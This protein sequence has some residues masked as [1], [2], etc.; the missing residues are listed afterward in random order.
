[1][2]S[3]RVTVCSESSSSER[4]YGVFQ[5]SVANLFQYTFVETC[6]AVLNFIGADVMATVCLTTQTKHVRTSDPSLKRP[7][8]LL[9]C[10]L[11]FKQ[12]VRGEKFAIALAIKLSTQAFDL[13]RSHSVLIAGL[14]RSSN[15]SSTRE[16][17]SESVSISNSSSFFMSQNF[18]NKLYYGSS[19]RG[20]AYRR[21]K[22]PTITG[23]MFS[24]CAL[25]SS[26]SYNELF[27]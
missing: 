27:T 5:C 3:N 13:K 19:I 14:I 25:A 20:F 2:G 7:E 6:I 24:I 26:T 10:C 17:R 12:H 22:N 15:S 8:S 16:R 11:C 1:M 4:L 23:S 21:L 18:L 9:S